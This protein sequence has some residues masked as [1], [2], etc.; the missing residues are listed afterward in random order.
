MLKYNAQTCRSLTIN[1]AN[2]KDKIELKKYA[3]QR[4]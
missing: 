3:E 2:L 4:F 1:A